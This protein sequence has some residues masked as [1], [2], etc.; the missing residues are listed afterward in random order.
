MLAQVDMP[1]MGG[2]GDSAS[3]AAARQARQ[4][5]EGA[6]A[7]APAGAQGNAARQGAQ[8]GDGQ[9]RG[10]FGPGG[11]NGAAGRRPNGTGAGRGNF[12][13]L[14]TVDA[15]GKLAVIP[16]RTG[17]SDGTSTEVQGPG[18]KEGMQ[19][20]AG[21]TQVDAGGGTTNP[22]QGGGPGGFRPGGF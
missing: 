11:F 21:L 16:V 3:R 2:R 10:G 19:V 13:M 17:I 4:N 1:A 15:A 12:A 18:I 22:F 9:A 14:W 5:G 7:G 20:I 6:A 8:G